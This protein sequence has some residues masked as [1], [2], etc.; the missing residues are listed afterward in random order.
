MSC[1]PGEIAKWN[2]SA[3]ACAADVDT[4]TDTNLDETAVDAFVANNGYLT[5]EVDGST[6]NE[7]NTTFELSGNDLELTDAGG[8]LTV[9]LSSYIDTN[10][11]YTS[12][13]GL[14]L[15]GTE[16]SIN[17]PTCAG[18]DKLQWTGTA[19]TCAADVDT[20]TNLDETAVDAF[21]ADNGYL[22]TETGRHNRKRTPKCNK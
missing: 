14:S 21:V 17:S 10:T 19:F 13:N 22:T 3:W 18:T 2:G 20:D 15:V 6:T 7:L 1:S 12:G 8:T 16:F 11:T 5:S 4:D 9:D